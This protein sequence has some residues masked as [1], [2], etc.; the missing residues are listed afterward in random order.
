MG[1]GGSYFA[2]FDTE[3]LRIS[4]EISRLEGLTRPR[5]KTAILTAIYGNS[6][7][8]QYIREAYLKRQL[9]DPCTN[10]YVNVPF[11]NGYF[12]FHCQEKH[13]PRLKLALNPLL[14]YFLHIQAKQRLL[15]CPEN[16]IS[17]DTLRTVSRNKF[18]LL[19]PE[20]RLGSALLSNDLFATLIAFVKNAKENSGIR[21]N[22]QS[23]KD[24]VWEV[25]E[26]HCVVCQKALHYDT[27]ECAH[28][29]S[30]AEGGISCHENLRPA[31]FACNRSMGTM[32]LFE[33]VVRTE[34]KG[35]EGLQA[36]KIVFWR[37]LINLTDYTATRKPEIAKI[38]GVGKR[39]RAI[40]SFL[41]LSW[42]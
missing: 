8:L 27:F 26:H 9:Y 36:D 21:V 40:A 3:I 24:R 37:S 25:Y 20:L 7:L 4:N 22:L 5:E 39:L 30:A 17:A 28:V 29:V 11:E 33:Y 19:S 34:A 1:I 41:E 35:M 42:E 16:M 13:L 23:I 32:H 14:D 2:K 18:I 15:D 31:C 38:M 10:T 12:G 6:I